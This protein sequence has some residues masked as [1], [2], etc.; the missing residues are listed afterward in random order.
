VSPYQSL[1]D[2]FVDVWY[3]ARVLVLGKVSRLGRYN[4]FLMAQLHQSGAGK[5]A[6]INAVFGTELAVSVPSHFKTDRPNESQG[7]I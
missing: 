3:R 6:L 7:S 5:S 2:P 4:P 1:L